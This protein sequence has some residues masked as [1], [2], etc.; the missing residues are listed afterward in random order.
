MIAASGGPQKVGSNRRRLCSQHD[1]HRALEQRVRQQRVVDMQYP[2]FRVLNQ[3]VHQQ[4]EA[5]P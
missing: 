4:C 2:G 3:G 1:S 5:T